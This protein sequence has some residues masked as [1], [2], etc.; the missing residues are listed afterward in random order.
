MQ[1]KKF[2]LIFLLV[3]LFS[4]PS[5]VNAQLF[6]NRSPGV[7]TTG[8]I[9]LYTLPASAL[10]TSMILGDFKGTW[11][12]TKGMLLNQ[13]LTYGIKVA[14]NKDRPL[15][16]DG[17]LAFP[18]GHTSTVFQAASFYHWRYGLVYSIPAYALAGFTAYSRLNATKHDGYD[19]LGGIV[20]GMVST[21]LFTTPYQ[22]ENMQLSF[23]GWEDTYLLTFRYNF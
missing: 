3:F 5:S 19:V 1:E 13:A 4:C 23:S 12:F 9:I 20:V 15:D 21:F 8:D 11:Q 7:E 2:F 16:G 6:G 22:R 14:I 18:S 10:A 17:G